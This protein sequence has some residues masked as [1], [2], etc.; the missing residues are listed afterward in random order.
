VSEV[1]GLLELREQGHEGPGHVGLLVLDGGRVLGHEGGLG[2]AEEGLYRDGV[3]RR[4]PDAREALVVDHHPR[5]PDLEGHV[6]G[7]LAD[8]GELDVP[9]LLQGMVDGVG[10]AVY[11]QLLHGGLGEGEAEE[12]GEHRAAA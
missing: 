10:D 4:S 12:E 11:P 9:T 3:D 2:A 6:V 8:V 7:A 1:V 5:L